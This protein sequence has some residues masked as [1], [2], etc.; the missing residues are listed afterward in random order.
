MKYHAVIEYGRKHYYYN[1]EK[2]SIIDKLLL[3]FINGQITLISSG[4][5]KKLL[6]LKNVKR[7]TFYRT[8]ARLVAS[9]EKTIIQQIQEKQFQKYE[10][11]EKLIQETKLNL[12][13]PQTY[14]LLQKSFATP[15]NQIFVIMKF[16]DNILDSAYEGVIIPLFEKYNI[17]VVRVDEIQDS[18]KISDQILDLISESKYVLSDLTGSRPNCYYET[19]FAH[20]MGKEIIL[21][22]NKSEKIHFDLAGYRFITWETESDFRKQLEARIKGIINK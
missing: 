5:G 2:N 7:L 15:K 13:S 20:A 17:D 14:S 18:G 21:T 19:G 4:K 16:G 3:P 1:F 6:N 9:D 12:T 10:C 22:C 11:T 8:R